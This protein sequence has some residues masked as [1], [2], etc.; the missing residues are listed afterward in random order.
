VLPILAALAFA[1]AFAW[2][3]MRSRA[4]IVRVRL[5]EARERESI[6]M[7]TELAAAARSSPDA[8]LERVAR[9]LGELEP[10]ID[11]VL[12][13]VPDG[14]DLVCTLARGARAEPFAGARVR[15]DGESAPARAARSH[16]RERGLARVVPGE[17]DGIAL[18][19]LDADRLVAVFYASAREPLRRTEPL[20]RCVARAEPAFALA[21]ERASDVRDA[22]FDGLTGLLT[23]RAFRSRLK[24]ALGSAGRAHGSLWFVDTDE[25]KTINDTLG[26]GTGDAVLAQMAALLRTHVGAGALAGRNGG[27]EFC[28]FLPG[29]P[30]S[31]GLERAER[32]RAAVATHDFGVA[33]GITASVGVAAHPLDGTTA[34]ALLERADA[35]MY[36]AKRAGRNRVAVA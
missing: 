6:A 21:R 8:V 19:L 2:A 25:F 13:Y 14:E 16:H 27:D 11:A 34:S 24:D 30:R 28:A 36:E 5:L 26:H 1:V 18:P 3:W 12:A 17:C 23:A 10:A 7:L 35:A 33:R 29:V 4:L 20:A 22:T 32:F 9:A 15:R 31:A